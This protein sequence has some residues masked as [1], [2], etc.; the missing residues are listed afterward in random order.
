M[1]TIAYYLGIACVCGMLFLSCERD[2]DEKN[3]QNHYEIDKSKVY[4][5]DDYE[6]RLKD[7]VW[8]YYR[9]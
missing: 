4:V 3:N 7:S 6:N 5:D 9:V 8:Y 2:D 1:K